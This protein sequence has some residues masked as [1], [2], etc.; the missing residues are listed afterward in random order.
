LGTS[1]CA[2]HVRDVDQKQCLDA[3]KAVRSPRAFVSAASDGWVT[4]I[5]EDADNFKLE[6]LAVTARKLSKHLSTDVIILGDWDNDIGFYFAFHDGKLVDRFEFS[7]GEEAGKPPGKPSKVA[8][9]FKWWKGA[10]KLEA[11]LKKSYRFESYRVKDIAAIFGI[12]DFRI[13]TKLADF[14]QPRT[15]EQLAQIPKDHPHGK[16]VHDQMKYVEFKA[17]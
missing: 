7:K 8:A 5:D 2:Y 4:V 16:V 10:A 3:L 9:A 1:L 12:P 13:W 14:E 15:P 17:S 6:S 11:W